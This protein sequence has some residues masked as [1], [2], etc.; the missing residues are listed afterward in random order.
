[1][2]SIIVHIY[3]SVIFTWCF[4]D[5][6]SHSVCRKNITTNTKQNEAHNWGKERDEIIMRRKKGN[7]TC[8]ED[9]ERKLLSEDYFYCT[10]WGIVVLGSDYMLLFT[11]DFL[12][13]QM[14]WWKHGNMLR[15]LFKINLAK[16]IKSIRHV[17]I[18][19]INL[20]FTLLL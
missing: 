20:C 12:F 16:L 1:M 13:P 9:R 11:L 19:H 14:S 6:K 17:I 7:I 10:Y 18:S 3:S 5:K 4:A 8:R 15:L 2:K